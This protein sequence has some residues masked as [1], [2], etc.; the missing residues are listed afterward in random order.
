M[1]DYATFLSRRQAASPTAGFMV[2][3]RELNGSLFPFQQACVARALRLG[4]SAMLFLGFLAG[5]NNLTQQRNDLT[6]QRAS[7]FLSHL[8]QLLVKLRGDAD[9]DFLIAIHMRSCVMPPVYRYLAAMSKRWYN[10]GIMMAIRRHIMAT[11]QTFA[12]LECGKVFQRYASLMS[13]PDRPFC[14]LACVGA[15][16]R[17]GS[18]LYCAMCDEPFYRHFAEQDIG[19]KMNQ[20]C[21]RPCYMEWRDVN[22]KPST[23]I[24]QGSR[25]VHRIIAEQYLGRPLTADEVIH[26]I[27]EDK[28]NNDPSNLAVL[29]NQTYHNKVHAGKVS[30]ADVRR[31]SLTAISQAH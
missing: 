9:G 5:L 31:L 23:Y 22:R 14:S 24:K 7:I 25:H 29:P 3:E 28:H 18:I 12:C 15:A 30:N 10:S 16:K 19:V 8:N 21:S 2:G 11:K 6:I 4:V 13:N 26:H 20:F 1:S 27:D 17:R